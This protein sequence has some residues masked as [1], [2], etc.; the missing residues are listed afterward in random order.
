M[1]LN[2]RQISSTAGYFADNCFDQKSCGCT[3]EMHHHT[4]LDIPKPPSITDRTSCA[5]AGSFSFAFLLFPR[6]QHISM[7]TAASVMI[8]NA[9]K[10]ISK[11]LF[12]EILNVSHGTSQPAIHVEILPFVHAHRSASKQIRSAPRAM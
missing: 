3:S 12:S 6:T 2:C 5:S 4:L 7:H 1:K 10:K 11:D 9:R 8:K